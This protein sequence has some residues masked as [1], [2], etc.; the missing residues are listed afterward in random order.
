[1]TLPSRSAEADP[2]TAGDTAAVIPDRCEDLVLPAVYTSMFADTPLNDPGWL[3]GSPAGR[4]EPSLLSQYADTYEV[5]NSASALRCIWR[6]PQA[7]T[8][9]IFVDI[10]T[11][12]ADIAAMHFSALEAQGS[13]CVDTLGGRMCQLIEGNPMYPV[14]DGFTFF[15]RGDTFIDVY[16]SNFPTNGLLADLVGT[17]WG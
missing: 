16:Q 8:T 10:G 12:G 6:D 4:I 1:L 5:V 2:A 11:V 14:D 3:Q 7:D 13:A 9:G 15:Y 17:L